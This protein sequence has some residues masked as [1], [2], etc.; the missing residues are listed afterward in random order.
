MTDNIVGLD[1]KPATLRAKEINAGAVKMLEELLAEA[2]EGRVCDLLIGYTTP[3]PDG[4]FLYQ[5]SWSGGHITLLGMANRM[6]Y[7]LNRGLDGQDKG[8]LGSD[9]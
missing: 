5:T 7:A 8:W 2:K 1:G 3:E 4:K 9:R 6:S